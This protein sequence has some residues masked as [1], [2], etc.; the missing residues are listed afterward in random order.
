MH[1]TNIGTIG[2]MA[3]TL[4]LPEATE[5]KLNERAAAEG[6]SAQ[7][8]ITEILESYLTSTAH[9]ERVMTTARGI[10]AD[11]AEALRRLGS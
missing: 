5:A 6:V 8:L 3:R 11:H 4:R 1:G 2:R 7:Q 9:R 10:M